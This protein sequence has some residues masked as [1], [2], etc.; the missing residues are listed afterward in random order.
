MLYGGGYELLVSDRP[1][2]TYLRSSPTARMQSEQATLREE[3]SSNTFNIK[4]QGVLTSEHST[5][6]HPSAER[7]ESFK[8][9]RMNLEALLDIKIQEFFTVKPYAQAYTRRTELRL[10]AADCATAGCAEASEATD[11][12]GF[13]TS[14]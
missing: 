7:T 10:V 5:T 6:S 11:P 1:I 12:V 8:T 4:Q 9:R 13:V 3:E 14:V 2:A